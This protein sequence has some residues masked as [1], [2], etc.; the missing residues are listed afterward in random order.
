[1]NRVLLQ[2]IQMTNVEDL[3]LQEF[4]NN[5]LPRRTLKK[6]DNYVFLFAMGGDGQKAPRKKIL[7]TLRSLIP[8]S[9]EI[10]SL[11]DNTQLSVAYLF[12]ADKKGVTARLLEVQNEVREVLTTLPD[13][14]LASNG[15]F[16]TYE[17]LKIG[18]FIFT[19]SDNNTGKL[20]DIIVPLMQT[21]NEEIFS[22]AEAYLNAHHDP[23]RIFP[24]K[25]TITAG[26]SEI[27][28]NRSAKKSDTDYDS[29]KSIIGITGQ[30][31]RSGKPNT[32]YISDADYFTIAKINGNS[33]CQGITTFFDHYLQ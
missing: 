7:G 5:S 22:K 13:D 3:N 11:P 8:E 2:Q 17:G 24:L 27:T 31:Q 1:M 26:T 33:K 29:K 6:D 28:E 30:L 16:G 12:D 18:S 23:N 32:A 15:S 20:E 10:K 9:G 21:G 25:L 14:A 19:G 4:G